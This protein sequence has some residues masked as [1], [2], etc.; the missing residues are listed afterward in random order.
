MSLELL[1]FRRA[2]ISAHRVPHSRFF[3]RLQPQ[4][5]DMREGCFWQKAGWHG[6]RSRVLIISTCE[7][8]AMP[9]AKCPPRV[10][11]SGQLPPEKTQDPE[12]A[13][14]SETPQ[15]SS[16]SDTAAQQRRDLP[17]PSEQ[18]A[19]K[20]KQNKTKISSVSERTACW[21]T[22]TIMLARHHIPAHLALREMIKLHNS[23]P[24]R[25][26]LPKC[27]FSSV[28]IMVPVVILFLRWVSRSS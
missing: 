6:Q 18:E 26:T 20:V 24:N 2:T 5:G 14:N 12:N 19:K 17:W 28:G 4:T 16:P 27:V 3:R 9:T 7:P 10:T 1:T 15:P 13:F 23:P 8:Q 25:R 21:V 22:P 11:H